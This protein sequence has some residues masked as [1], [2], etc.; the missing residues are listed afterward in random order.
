M[1]TVFRQVKNT[2]ILNRYFILLIIFYFVIRIANLISFPIFNDEAIY[3]DWGWRETHV[4]GYLYYS[5]YDAKQPLLMWVFGVMEQL[6]PDPLFA[7]RIISVFAGFLTLFGIYKIASKLFNTKVALLSALT[8]TFVPLFSFYDR[9]ALMESSI[10]AIGIWAGYFLLNLFDRKYYKYAIFLGIIFGIGFFIKSSALVF[11]ISFLVS[12]IY[13]IKLASKKVKVLEITILTLIVFLCSIVLLIINPQFWET[14]HTNSRFTLTFS[15]FLSFPANI[16]ISSFITHFKISFFYL[17]P[18]LFITSL[19]GSFLIF[20]K[21]SKHKLFLL[22]FFISFLIANFS[23][24][25]G[26]DRYIVSFMPFLVICSSFI[27]MEIFNKNKA[28][29]YFMIIIFTLIPFILT[30]YQL[31]NFPGYILTMGKMS[32]YTHPSYLSGF[33]SGYGINEAIEYF[34]NL[35]KKEKFVIGVAENTG[36]PESAFQIYFNKNK[37]AKTVYMDEKLLG[38]DLSKYDCLSTDVKVYFVSRDNQ[39]AGLEK[40]LEKVTEFKNPYGIN[41]IGVY[42]LKKNCKGKSLDIS[43]TKT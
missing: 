30:M 43:I 34:K 21:T 3:L 12:L 6:L 32:G 35:S 1:N 13:L 38:V 19:I 24:R 31:I 11:L 36:N 2:L 20:K 7:G 17:T 33:T 27:L 5:L 15:E 18:L 23:V 16:W 42:Q 4:P 22:Y 9:L 8:Y 10:S 39:Q 14:L 37:N 29:G 26:F 40:F 41:S 25:G 28:N